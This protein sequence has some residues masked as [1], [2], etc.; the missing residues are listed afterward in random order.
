MPAVA[1]IGATVPG[2][3][4]EA[5]L[6]VA[7][8]T[9]RIVIADTAIWFVEFTL[10]LSVAIGIKVALE[11]RRTVGGAVGLGLADRAVTH[12]T[13]I[14]PAGVSDCTHRAGRVV[15]CIADSATL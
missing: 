1:T 9:L 10:A 7:A 14:G 15:R 3:A 13:T 4:A 12:H 8:S 11:I 6:A 5:V 2:G